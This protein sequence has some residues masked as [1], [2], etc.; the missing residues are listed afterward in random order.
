[1][2]RRGK[3]NPLPELRRSPSSA[4]SASS[5]TGSAAHSSGILPCPCP[6]SVLVRFLYSSW[7]FRNFF[8]DFS[9]VFMLFGLWSLI[10]GVLRRFLLWVFVLFGRF[11]WLWRPVCAKNPILWKRNAD[12]GGRNFIFWAKNCWHCDSV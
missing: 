8:S 7:I 3:S 9:V 12:F 11:C 1:M 6:F 4:L 2:G 5:S 10:L